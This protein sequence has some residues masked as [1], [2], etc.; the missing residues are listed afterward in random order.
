M[1]FD[2]YRCKL[3]TSADGEAIE[4]VLQEGEMCSGV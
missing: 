1:R 4:V 3:I 2:K